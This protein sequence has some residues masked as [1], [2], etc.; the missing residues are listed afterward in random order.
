M[1]GTYPKGSEAN[2]QDWHGY[3]K[4]AIDN[5]PTPIIFSGNEIGCKYPTGKSLSTTPKSNPVRRIYEYM[6]RK[7]GN[8]MNHCSFDQTSVLAGIRDPKRY[9][10]LTPSGTNTVYLDEKRKTF[11]AWKPTPDSGHRYL[12]PKRQYQERHISHQRPHER[13]AWRGTPL[14]TVTTA[15]P[16]L[17]CAEGADIRAGVAKIDQR[18]MVTISRQIS[19]GRAAAIAEIVVQDGCHAGVTDE[20]HETER[21]RRCNT[22]AQNSLCPH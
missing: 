12:L 9:W 16:A 21:C 7:R 19:H 13:S 10:D 4:N 6:S 22:R 5:W 17:A 3:A 1:G 11:S 14:R 2:L 8:S 20:R 18:A 15:H